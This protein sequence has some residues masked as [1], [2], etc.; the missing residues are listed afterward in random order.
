MVRNGKLNLLLKNIINL[1]FSSLEIQRRLIQTKS[2]YTFFYSVWKETSYKFSK[3]AAAKKAD[4]DF[5]IKSKIL[6]IFTIFYL[7][8]WIL[9]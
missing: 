6:Q 8:T 1:V 7:F 3:V 9:V 4:D 5:A 2:Y